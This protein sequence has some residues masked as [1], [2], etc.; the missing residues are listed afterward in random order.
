MPNK[1]KEEEILDMINGLPEGK[2]FKNIAEKVIADERI[3]DE[4][5][6]HLFEKASIG[7]SATLANYIR[8]K[9]HGDKTFFNRNFHI[10][11]PKQSI[12][13]SSQSHE[14]AALDHGYA[15]SIHF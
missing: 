2:I 9:R 15:R 11:K 8:E 14:F 12:I 4:E 1:K 10:L 7:L 5:A 6:I 13:Y 3:T